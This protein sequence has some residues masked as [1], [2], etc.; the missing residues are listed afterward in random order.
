[1]VGVRRCRLLSPRFTRERRCS[2]KR[3]NL[4]LVVMALLALALFAPAAV[5]QDDD[6]DDDDD[7][8]GAI[9]QQG[10]QLPKTGGPAL[11]VPAAGALLLGSGVVGVV[12]LSRSRN[13]S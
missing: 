5:A 11:V 4:L 10:A 3:R 8:D 7:D 12:A 9:A 2:M 1:M 6:D 13:D